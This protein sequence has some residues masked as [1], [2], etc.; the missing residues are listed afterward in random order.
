[1]IK[2]MTLDVAD[3]SVTSQRSRK[4]STADFSESLAL[5]MPTMPLA[6]TATPMSAWSSSSATSRGMAA[7]VSQTESLSARGAASR[8]RSDSSTNG[9][10]ISSREAADEESDS[11]RTQNDNRR[12]DRND[13]KNATE[14]TDSSVDGRDDG[15][16]SSSS[17]EATANAQ[18][19]STSSGDASMSTATSNA[20]TGIDISS[21]TPTSAQEAPDLTPTPTAA[22]TEQAKSAKSGQSTQTPLSAKILPNTD[23]Q[24]GTQTVG[25][26]TV[27]FETG[28][29]QQILR[30]LCDRVDASQSS[31]HAAMG[32]ASTASSTSA[33]LASASA[34]TPTSTLAMLANGATDDVDGTASVSKAFNI[35]RNSLSQRHSQLTVQLDPAELGKMKLDVRLT[36]NHMRLTVVTET[37]EAGKL[38]TERFETLKTSL[39]AQGITISRFDVTVRPSASGDAQNNNDNQQQQSSNNGQ[40]Q[41]TNQQQPS[42]GDSSDASAFEKMFADD[43]DESIADDADADLS[44]MAAASSA[45]HTMNFSG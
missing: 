24:V 12:V 21:L 4:R 30:G 1:M 15:S 33:K 23:A 45:D 29:A 39:E 37:A 2:K 18:E 26:Q 40:Q 31:T 36:D 28:L 14:S 32:T 41:P 38:M 22:A 10:D 5:A 42:Q 35:V 44:L 34:T 3:L 6:N 9:N 25:R 20:A 16:A 43:T 13:E 7:D 19:G 17:T 8:D 27:T 11:E